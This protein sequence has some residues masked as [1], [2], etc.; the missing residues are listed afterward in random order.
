MN[1]KQESVNFDVLTGQEH[2]LDNEVLETAIRAE[3][4]Y[5][6]ND[7]WDVEAGVQLVETGIRNFRGIN[8][9]A[10]R[11]LSKEVLRTTSL[12]VEGNA[13]LQTYTTIAAGIRA[14][15]FD[16]LNK[17]RIEP[18]LTILKK[19]GGPFSL[20]VLVETKSQTT[21]QVVDFQTDFL[22]VENRK[23]ELVN[24]ENIP[25]LTSRQASVG[26]NYQ[27]KSLLVSLEGFIKGVD[28]VVTAS[29]GFLNQFQFERTFGSYVSHGIELLV[30]PS[31]GDLDSWL[32]YSFLNS[33]Y[34]FSDLVPQE[35]RNNFDISHALSV[36]LT[37]QL[38]NL[39]LSSG[40]NYRSGVPFTEPQGIDKTNDE[41]V[42]D[43]P[44]AMTL[45]NYF[46][47]DFSAKYR[48]DISDK[49][50]GNCGI[51]V[52]NLTNREN[53][54]NTLSSI[55]EDGELS[56]VNQKALGITP[57]VSVRISYKF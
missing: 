11:S 1:Y 7:T 41:I 54:I 47:M 12:Y 21:V 10:F 51:A 13:H 2:I 8:L 52:W 26:V 42:Y 23:W 37:Y 36:G 3:G 45:D 4:S 31:F 48:F 46:R 22:G 50:S 34:T 17:Y 19:L 39:E 14:N 53:I 57:N 5:F 18:R 33:D 29:Q 55:T 16:K 35:F 20:E 24:G 9:P 43:F 44:N 28:G 27:K 56:Q 6:L 15:Y 49:W 30:N 25:L 38:N 40:V 32:T